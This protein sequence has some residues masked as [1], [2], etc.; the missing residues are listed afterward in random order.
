MLSKVFD[1]DLT[2]NVYV[3]IKDTH[4]FERC[5]KLHEI[6]ANANYDFHHNMIKK[7]QPIRSDESQIMQLADVLI[8]AV[9]YANRFNN[10]KNKEKSAAKKEIVELIKSKTHY[11]LSKSTYL[12]EK[13]FNMLFWEGI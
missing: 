3:D 11:S 7:I 12:N 10:D 9:L 5:N 4:S 2:Y 1:K 6:C 8:G 13:K